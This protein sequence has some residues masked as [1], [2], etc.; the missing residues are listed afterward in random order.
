MFQRIKLLVRTDFIFLI[1]GTENDRKTELPT[2]EIEIFFLFYDRKHNFIFRNR[3]Y[4]EINFS[5][6]FFPFLPSSPHGPFRILLS[7]PIPLPF[8]PFFFIH[9]RETRY[10]N[11]IDIY[12]HIHPPLSL[13]HRNSPPSQCHI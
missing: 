4:N 6:P 10:N 13:I 3:N 12:I 9:V 11:Q 7:P 2:V 8:P 5:S 1:I